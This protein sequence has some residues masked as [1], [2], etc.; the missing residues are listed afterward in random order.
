MRIF[1]NKSFYIWTKTEYFQN[2]QYSF[3][4]LLQ[5]DFRRN[6][7]FVFND[8]NLWCSPLRLTVFL[9]QLGYTV[10]PFLALISS[11]INVVAWLGRRNPIKAGRK[12]AFETVVKDLFNFLK[13]IY[14]YIFSFST[15]NRDPAWEA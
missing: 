13:R 14:I 10:T 4:L 5:K 11:S 12:P 6:K 3:F 8:E 1:L 2:L 15:L 9:T 7:R